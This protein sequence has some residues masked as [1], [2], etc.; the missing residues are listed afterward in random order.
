MRARDKKDESMATQISKILSGKPAAELRKKEIEAKKERLAARS[1]KPVA[2][3]LA[4]VRVGDSPDTQ[5]YSKSLDRVLEQYGVRHIEKICRTEAELLR[6]IR[7]LYADKELTGILIFSP[8]PESINAKNVFLNLPLHKDVEGRTFIKRNPFGVFS[9]TAKAVMTLLW[10]LQ[11]SLD[12]GYSV[13]GKHAVMVGHSDLVGKPT[14]MLLSDE[15][16]T[17]TVCHKD[18]QN[19]QKYISEADILVVAIGKPGVVQSSWIK[20]GAVVIDVGENVVNGRVVGDIDFESALKSAS[21]IS[22]VPGG[23]GPLTNLM[24]VE[25]LLTLYEFKDALDGNH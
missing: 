7:P 14:A 24:V 19:I 16:A 5:L 10:Y 12:P 11:K 23:V 1:K 6:E 3:S 4:T 18:T 21:Y 15:G 9:P 17:V 20:S 2:L 25:N 22:P 8:I 13:K